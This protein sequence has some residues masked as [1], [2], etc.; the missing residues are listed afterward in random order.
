MKID[1]YQQLPLF[2][3]SSELNKRHIKK[4]L[5]CIIF[6]NFGAM[7]LGDEAIL[8]GEIQELQ[9]LP[10]IAITVVARYPEEIK[11]LHPVQSISLYNLRE[12]RRA[13]KKSDFVI[14]G[15]GGL[16]NKVE[17]SFIGFGYQLYMLFV[18]F[19]LPRFY[20]RKLYI[21][22][23]GIYSNANPLILSLAY[24]LIKYA[25]IVTVR[26]HHAY[27]FLKSKNIHAMLYKDNSFLMDLAPMDIVMK[28]EVFKKE[29]RKNRENVGISLVK[30]DSPTE[31]KRLI[32][33]MSVFILNNYKK[34][35]FWFYPADYNPEYE[36][37][38]KLMERVLLEAKKHTNDPIVLHTVPMNASP[39]VFFGSIKLMNRFI[40]MRFHAAVFAYRNK[41][42]FTGISYDKKVASF[43][44]A[45]GKTSLSLKNFTAKDIE[46]NIL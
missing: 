25:S 31:E 36:G 44:E 9:K 18:F 43:L 30:P 21:L 24:P 14:V 6:G 15:G 13:I 41:V 10:N 20:K 40:A 38:H 35:D 3:F 23:V 26:D 8:S 27:T 37:D 1:K 12:I 19:F 32:H 46:D 28:E 39:Q 29:Y 17:R 11:R 22:G 45:V 7:N 16:I 42:C 4:N 2:H 34:T 33:E 5:K